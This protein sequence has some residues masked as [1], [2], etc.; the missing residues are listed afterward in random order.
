MW[1]CRET[2]RLTYPSGN[3]SPV[4]DWSIM[5]LYC[6]IFYTTF[7]LEKSTVWLSYVP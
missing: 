6:Q 4:D 1:S 3:K 5:S 2:L 7:L